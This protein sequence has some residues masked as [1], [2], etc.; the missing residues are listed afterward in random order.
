[1][2]SE[3]ALPQGF[4]ALEPFV[5]YW[6]AATLSDRDTRRLDSTEAQRVSFY[7]GARGLVAPAMDYLDSKPLADHD[8]RDRR[9]MNL[10]LGLVHVALAVEAQRDG[11]AEHALGGRQVPITR[12]H[13][14]PRATSAG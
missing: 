11:E 3:N 14:D 10:M 13:A 4:E 8:A 1:M 2:T 12:G 6:A 9:L 5:G 7:D